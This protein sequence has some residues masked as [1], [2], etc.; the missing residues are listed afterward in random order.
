MLAVTKFKTSYI[1]YS[2][3][4]KEI[5]Y[6]SFIHYFISLFHLLLNANWMLKLLYTI[7]FTTRTRY[8]LLEIAHSIFVVYVLWQYFFKHIYYYILIRENFLYFEECYRS[9]HVIAYSKG[10]VV[11]LG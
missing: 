6:A 3:S 8:G 11:C 9:L 10:F 4:I 2:F 1:V 7:R 5:F